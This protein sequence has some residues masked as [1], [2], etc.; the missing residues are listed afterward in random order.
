MGLV[1][2]LCFVLQYSLV[3]SPEGTTHMNCAVV[4]PFFTAQYY[5]LFINWCLDMCI[6]L[7]LSLGL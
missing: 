2:I 7:D 3:A 4:A 1:T 5:A 6:G